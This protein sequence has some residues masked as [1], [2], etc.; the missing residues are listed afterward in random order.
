[1]IMDINEITS[2]I[3]RTKQFKERLL[4]NNNINDSVIAQYNQLEPQFKNIFPQIL[5]DEYGPIL[6]LPSFYRF[7]GNEEIYFERQY[8]RI[9]SRLEFMISFFPNEINEKILTINFIQIENFHQIINS[10]SI[11]NSDKLVINNYIT[12]LQEEIK[13]P[14]LNKQ[15]IIEIITKIIM[16]DIP[17]EII[18]GLLKLL[19]NVWINK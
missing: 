6:P 4:L 2:F 18:I 5:F 8:H 9:M 3:S 17:K 12:Q 19:F 10:L 14:I 15:R 13:K 11:D 1:M 16:Y 7:F